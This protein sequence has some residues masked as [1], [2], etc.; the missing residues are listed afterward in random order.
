MCDVELICEKNFSE[1]DG[2]IVDRFIEFQRAIIEKDEAKLNEMLSDDYELVHMAGKRQ[3]KTEFIG[4]VMDGTLNYFKSQ[5]E[6]QTIIHDDEDSASLVGDVTLTAKV[7]GIDGKWTL[8]SVVN[9]KK[10]DDVWY[11]GDWDN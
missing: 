8:D 5:I 1:A 3:S 9:F 6:D 7:Y 2:E 4:E 10:V 11:I